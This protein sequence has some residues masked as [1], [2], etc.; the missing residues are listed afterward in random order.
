MAPSSTLRIDQYFYDPDNQ[1]GM[2]HYSFLG[3]AFNYISGLIGKQANHDIQINTPMGSIGIRGTELIANLTAQNI[4]VYLDE[5][6]ITATPGNSGALG[7]Y[8]AQTV[9]TFDPNSAT[10]SAFSQSDYDAVKQ[11][12]TGST[13]DTQPPVVSC[14]TAPAGWQAMNVTIGCTASDSGSGLANAADASFTLSTTVSSTETANAATASHQ[15][16]DKANNCAT[17]GPISGIMI[18]LKP[19]SISISAPAG[20]TNYVLNSSPAANYQCTDGGSGI[21]RCT[22]PVVTGTT[23]DTS[24]VGSHNFQVNA[25]DKAG[26]VSSAS[27]SY[28][29]SYNVCLLFD[30]TRSV[31]SGSTVP[32]RIALCDSGGIDASSSAVVVQAVSLTHISTNASQVLE[33]SGSANPDGNFRF[34]PTLGTT[35]GYIFNLQTTGLTT[36]TY[37][38][39]FTAGSDPSPHIVTFQVR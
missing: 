5:G 24:S 33:S 3:G 21:Q 12:I 26:N 36:G 39:T 27:V 28:S 22:G 6:E 15:V 4:I 34:D 13:P 8:L 29:V 1:A 16:C 32:I 10:T 19:P 9:I 2:A 14:G 35:G 11:Q 37:A 17:A 18:D 7:D 23:F 20:N 30:N 31:Q 38:L 25:T